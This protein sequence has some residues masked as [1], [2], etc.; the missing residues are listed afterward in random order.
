MARNTHPDSGLA[1]ALVIVVL[2]VLVGMA[3]LGTF[4]HLTGTGL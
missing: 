2:G 4:G 3:L 1:L